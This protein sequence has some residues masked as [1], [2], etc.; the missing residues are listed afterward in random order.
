MAMVLWDAR[1]II[2]DV[3]LQK[4]RTINGDCYVSLL[5]QTLKI[6]RP[7]LACAVLMAKIVELLPR[8]PNWIRVLFIIPKLEKKGSFEKNSTS[9]PLSK[10]TPIWRTFRN[11]TFLTWNN[12]RNAGRSVSGWNGNKLSCEI[13]TNQIKRK[14][15][16]ILLYLLTYPRSK[17]SFFHFT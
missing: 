6:K 11:I 8:P 10:Q 16:S 17:I 14:C 5:S 4:G 13:K 12:W 3:Y 1:R 15:F 7:H 9:T 2:N